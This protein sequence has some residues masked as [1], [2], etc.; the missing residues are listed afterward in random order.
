VGGGGELVELEV[1]DGTLR[2]EFDEDVGGG[3]V[4]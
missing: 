4:V 1:V 3:T 2:L